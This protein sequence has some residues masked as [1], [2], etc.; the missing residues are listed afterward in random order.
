M[1]NQTD[2]R[3]PGTNPS[4]AT[5]TDILDQERIGELLDLGGTEVIAEIAEAFFENA[6][7]LMSEMQ[8]ALAR[9]DMKPVWDHAHQMKST[10]AA[11]GAALLSQVAAEL[12]QVAKTDQFE[13]AR[14]LLNRLQQEFVVAVRE[15]RHIYRQSG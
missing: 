5:G 10:S 12:E 2:P 4:A 13:T 8:A 6:E 11:L 14:S 3:Q 15:L 9:N 7:N 1:P